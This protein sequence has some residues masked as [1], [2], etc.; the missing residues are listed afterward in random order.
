MK[1]FSNL[2]I[3]RNTLAG[4]LAGFSLFSYVPISPV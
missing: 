4:L 1:N 2:Y 3:M